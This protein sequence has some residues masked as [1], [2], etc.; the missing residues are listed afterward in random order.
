MSITCK[1]AVH[2]CYVIQALMLVACIETCMLGH[3]RCIIRLESFKASSFVALCGPY[4]SESQHW[5]DALV[6]PCRRAAS[7]DSHTI[8]KCIPG[9]LLCWHSISASC[10]SLVCGDKFPKQLP[11]C[12]SE[13]SS[14][15]PLFAM[16]FKT[17]C[18]NNP[19]CNMHQAHDLD[20]TPRTC[21]QSQDL[22]N[23]NRCKSSVTSPAVMPLCTCATKGYL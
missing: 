11:V 13:A 10:I 12:S 23:A 6:H 7:I 2:T 4:R 15:M 21:M 14:R 17:C 22:E 8:W 20:I 1:P 18:C 9:V 16:C 3:A 5:R 19:A